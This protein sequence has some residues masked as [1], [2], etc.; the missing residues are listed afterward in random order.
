MQFTIARANG[1]F[2][3]PWKVPV[4]VRALAKNDVL[5]LTR[6]TTAHSLAVE[7]SLQEAACETRTVTSPFGSFEQGSRTDTVPVAALAWKA[8]LQA[9]NIHMF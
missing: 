8:I 6:K 5:F 1:C 4:L 2:Y 7:T 3:V 9:A